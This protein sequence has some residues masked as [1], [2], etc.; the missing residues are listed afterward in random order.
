[1]Y[2][3]V[4]LGDLDET[5]KSGRYKGWNKYGRN[6]L[7]Y[8]LPHYNQIDQLA[9]MDTDEGSFNFEQVIVK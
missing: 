6:M 9:N 5:V 4:G 7:R 3:F 8:W 2:P 1:M